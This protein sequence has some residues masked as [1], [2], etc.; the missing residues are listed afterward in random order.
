[1][2]DEHPPLHPALD[3]LLKRRP[4]EAAI[5][6]FLAE[7]EFP[8]QSG[9]TSTFVYAGPAEEVRLRHWIYGLSS[10]QAF[11]RLPDAE[12]W[13]LTLDLPPR[14]RVEYKFEV[15]NGE[16]QV[17]ND[18]LNPR[19]ARD[20]FGANSVCHG[21]GYETPE[22]TLRDPEARHGQVEEVAIDSRALGGSREVKVY[23]PARLHPR[24][25]Y[26]LLVV[27]D[28]NDYLE[29]TGLATVLDNLIFRL[30][31][32]PLVVALIQ[33][34]NRLDEYGANARHARFLINELIPALEERFPAGGRPADRGLM[35][36]SFGAV[37]ALSTAWRSPGFAG[38]LL[39]QSGSFAFTDIGESW[40]GPEFEPVIRFMNRFR[41]RPLRPAERAYV[42]C[43]IYESLIYENRSI[44]PVLQSTG[45]DVRYAESRD[46][47][48]WESWRD[49]LRE[50]LSFLFP[51]PLWMVY[52]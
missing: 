40:R 1:M 35:G 51:G 21:L 28:G 37:A 31:I 7:N 23:V 22:W 45:M 12:L 41:R 34:P 24:R 5:G 46:G 47:H 42:S 26:P 19:L 16:R 13:A 4:D 15:V 44:L 50:G 27:H 17:I 30:E 2:T 3:R 14:S 49:R 10:S 52:E 6:R 36:A 25:R 20:P 43:G 33:S 29:Y 39:L 38:R 9:R 48:N 32:A 8:L 11:R 18:P